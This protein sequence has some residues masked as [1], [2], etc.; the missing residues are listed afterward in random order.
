[1]SNPGAVGDAPASDI[2]DAIGQHSSLFDVDELESSSE[3]SMFAQPSTTFSFS[4][5]SST[6][7][8]I[9]TTNVLRK[10]SSGKLTEA[11]ETLSPSEELDTENSEES[12]TPTEPFVS[13]IKEQQEPE[14]IY[15]MFPPPPPSINFITESPLKMFKQFTSTENSDELKPILSEPSY[16]LI[17]CPKLPVDNSSDKS[18]AQTVST[19]T[20]KFNGPDNSESEYINSDCSNQSTTA[21]SLI[22]EKVSSNCATTKQSSC[23]ETKPSTPSVNTKSSKTFEFEQGLTSSENSEN[24]AILEGLTNQNKTKEQPQST[25]LPE[26]TNDNNTY[27]KAIHNSLNEALNTVFSDGAIKVGNLANRIIENLKEASGSKDQLAEMLQKNEELKVFVGKLIQLLEEKTNLC[28]NLEKQNLALS[29][30]ASS[31][32]DVINITKDL[33]SIR[34]M[35]VEHLHTDLNSMEMMIKDERTRHNL[36]VQRLQEAMK[37]NEQL[38]KEYL[39]QMDLFTKLKGKYTEKILDLSDNNRQ[40]NDFIKSQ[41]LQFVPKERTKMVEAIVNESDKK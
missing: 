29:H 24:E 22:S 31:L 18:L 35:E 33:L 7:E 16:T 25:C 20:I 9:E 12:F 3:N 34:N 13:E 1:M 32:K 4:D 8:I 10:E 39:L 37:L 23:F 40:F 11:T 41:N 6:E 30:Q 5:H 21:S 38:K 2:T 19:Q 28:S 14:G 27:E 17:V 15:C 36:S 26:N